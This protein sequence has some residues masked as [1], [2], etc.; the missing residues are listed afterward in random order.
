MMTDALATSAIA[1]D[2]FSILRLA[3]ASTLIV[4]ILLGLLMR[5]LAF[6]GATFAQR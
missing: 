4:T 1:F 5:S 2:A 3:R 6:G